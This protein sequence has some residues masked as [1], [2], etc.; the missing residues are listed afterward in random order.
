MAQITGETLREALKANVH[1]SAT[2]QTD[3]LPSYIKPGKEFAKHERVAHSR[4][5]YVRG[6]RTSIQP[7]A[8]SPS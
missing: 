8:F 4:A 1:P 2:L 5:E 6:R 3:E 7:R